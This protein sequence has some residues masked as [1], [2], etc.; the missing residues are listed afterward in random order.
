MSAASIN[1]RRRAALAFPS[2]ARANFELGGAL[3][4]V[5]AFGEAVLRL[6][7]TILLDPDHVK[8]HRDLALALLRT[9]RSADA[10]SHFETA[11]RL[12]RHV[13]T[14]SEL[15]D[16]HVGRG[17]A[18][19]DLRNMQGAA[20]A[21]A[22]SFEIDKSHAEAYLRLGR[23][24]ARNGQ[25]SESA[26]V[27]RRMVEHCPRNLDGNLALA[28]TLERE[29]LHAAAS[30]V[31]ALV[32]E[33]A[34]WHRVAATRRVIALQR[35]GHYGAA[36][37]A[38]RTALGNADNDRRSDLSKKDD[39]DA[40]RELVDILAETQRL[41]ASS[42]NAL[43]LLEEAR[44]DM[45]SGKLSLALERGASAIAIVPSTRRGVAQTAMGQIQEEGRLLEDAARS[46]AR[47]L[48][49]S[50]P[51]PRAQF[52]LAKLMV[53]QGRLPGAAKLCRA[54]LDRANRWPDDS[55]IEETLLDARLLL[56]RAY[57]ALG[58]L[59]AAYE[60]Y[61]FALENTTWQDRD[62]ALK[63]FNEVARSISNVAERGP[64]MLEARRPHQ[65][66]VAF[67]AALASDPSDDAS[68]LGLARALV[69]TGEEHRWDAALDLF[70]SVEL[71]RFDSLSLRDYGILLRRAGSYADSLGCFR[72][73]S[74]LSP[75]DP[76][77]LHLL[78]SQ[79]FHM[80]DA[81]AAVD[82]LRRAADSLSSESG[83]LN[84]L[85]AALFSLGRLDEA[86]ATFA[87]SIALVPAF[88]THVNYA[89]V[90]RDQNKHDD[91]A[92]HLKL[93]LNAIEARDADATAGKAGEVEIAVRMP[94]RDVPEDEM[95]N[96]ARLLTDVC[97]TS[98]NDLPCAIEAATY[99][100]NLLDAAMRPVDMI[101]T[102]WLRGRMLQEAHRAPEGLSDLSQAVSIARV[103]DPPYGRIKM[104]EAEY[105]KAKG[106]R[107]HAPAIRE[108]DSVHS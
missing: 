7:A 50:P 80:G 100:I 45:R 33:I 11:A 62:L 46:Y 58:H 76:E 84:D 52:Y 60:Q 10:L 72:R 85:G 5:G 42:E 14:V 106:N 51:D 22:R 25:N 81:N 30:R 79:L 75:D 93:A 3:L 101:E 44:E 82:V 104:L 66:V 1:Y 56:A 23:L 87:R 18:L 71:S 63:E 64:A 32:L 92:R 99:M 89:I 86:E 77:I 34:P 4:S 36:E 57:R 27:F 48:T 103:A 102:L 88:E 47:A 69:A 49:E 70:R 41:R 35:V 12:G 95:L 83:I 59:R 90:L 96:V 54:L 107:D 91:A 21:Y 68:R 65:A 24:L 19:E 43:A 16:V 26:D 98:L 53:K 94:D 61:E 105:Y 73:A 74:E 13:L 15:A 78:G 20:K 29:N 38:A 2:S 8:A 6:R 39:D 28:Q 17:Q 67:E 37:Q 40:R 108:R 97:R 55:L 31:Y 9:Q